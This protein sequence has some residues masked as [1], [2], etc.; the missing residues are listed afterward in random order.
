MM[1]ARPPPGT[2]RKARCSVVFG[3]LFV[4]ARTS[5]PDSVT[6]VLLPPCP[7]RARVGSAGP[8]GGQA[9][10]RRSFPPQ[11]GLPPE[12][13]LAMAT[14]RLLLLSPTAVFQKGGAAAWRKERKR[15]GG[16]KEKEEGVLP[17]GT[18]QDHAGRVEEEEG[19][20]GPGRTGGGRIS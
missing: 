14:K 6:V 1:Q 8:Q 12:R 2:I 4:K 20:G 11:P 5:L 7:P 15:R 17:A 9:A 16:G 13:S 10:R 18:G 3:F 19:L